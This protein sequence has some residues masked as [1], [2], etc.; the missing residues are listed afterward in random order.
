MPLIC[1]GV[2]V[3]QEVLKVPN[4]CNYEQCLPSTID[5]LLD[6]SHHLFLQVNLKLLRL[7]IKDI[8]PVK[9]S[10]RAGMDNIPLSCTPLTASSVLST[11]FASSTSEIIR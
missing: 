1:S 2:V 11:I 7:G 5:A 8:L 6:S 10:Y 9:F 3:L 4:I